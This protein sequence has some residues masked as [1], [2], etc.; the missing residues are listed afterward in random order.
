[1]NDLFMLYLWTRIDAFGWLVTAIAVLS[2]IAICASAIFYW[3]NDP[4][5]WISDSKKL[6]AKN[7]RKLA[8]SGQRFSIIAACIAI[9]LS[10]ALPTQKDVAIIAGGWMIKEAA[11]SQTAQDI[12]EKTYRLI[13]GKIEAELQKIDG[14]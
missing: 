10:V 14:K 6:C 12:G 1:M 2:V 13:V 5:Q 3:D 11:T 9:P 8:I 7:N 4:D